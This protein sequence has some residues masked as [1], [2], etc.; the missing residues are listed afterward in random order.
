M[1]TY[2]KY[3]PTGISGGGGGGGGGGVTSLNGETG[4]VTITAGTGISVTEPTGTTIQVA[5][6]GA[7]DAFTIVQTPFGT[8]PTATT[9]NSTLTL[10]STDNSVAITGNSTTN[11]I[12]LSTAAED[13]TFT[14]I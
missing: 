8:A 1:S 3:T 11:T 10:T 4:A 14:A 6:T 9:G 7:L 2:A 13:V 5:N 12:N